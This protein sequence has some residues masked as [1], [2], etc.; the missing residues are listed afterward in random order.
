MYQDNKTAYLNAANPQYQYQN[1][2]YKKYSKT[3]RAAALSA[4]IAFL[5]AN[6]SKLS[7]RLFSSISN[8]PLKNVRNGLNTVFTFASDDATLGRS[9]TELRHA[10]TTDMS[11][12][13]RSNFID[14]PD[15][16]FVA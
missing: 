16:V 15:F 12:L 7:H 11:E 2:G 9:L 3:R 10:L 13:R 8:K 1:R 5:E 14:A 6:I 4:R